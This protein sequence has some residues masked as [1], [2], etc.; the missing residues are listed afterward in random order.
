MFMRVSFIMETAGGWAVVNSQPNCERLA[1]DNLVRQEFNVY[2]PMARTRVKHARRSRDILR[3]LFPCY[4]FV[5]LAPQTQRWRPIMS[6]FG[7]RMLVRFGEQ[8]AL[9]ADDFIQELKLHE[10]DGE[11][12]HPAKSYK[13]GQ[14]VEVANGSFSGLVGTIIKMDD[15]D[16][17][18]VLMNLLSRQVK[19][20]LAA[21]MVIA[22]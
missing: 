18:V 14:R 9:I 11:I 15:K 16:R 20:Q 10:I 8:P 19:V 22:A 13:V 12:V 1:L 2:C 5:H 21:G 4:L 17:L 7:V 3:P 6:T